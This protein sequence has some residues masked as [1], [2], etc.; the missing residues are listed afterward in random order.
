[1]HGFLNRFPGAGSDIAYKILQIL[2]MSLYGGTL[3]GD[4]T[5]SVYQL[6][7]WT[8]PKITMEEKTFTGAELETMEE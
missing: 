8:I 5:S 1:M 2:E 3:S 7:I 6:P 4:R